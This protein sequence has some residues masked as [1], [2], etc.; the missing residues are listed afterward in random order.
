MKSALTTLLLI[1]SFLYCAAVL[2]VP[3]AETFYQ[4]LG[5]STDL[6]WAHEALLAY[7]DWADA[8]PLIVLGG[9]PTAI[10]FLVRY[11]PKRRRING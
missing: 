7:F 11:K 10:L 1:G 2:H 4:Q 5:V 8:N 3:F 6:R 9:Y